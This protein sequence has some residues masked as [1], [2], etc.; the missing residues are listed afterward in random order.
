MNVKMYRCT[1]GMRK[2]VGRRRSVPDRTRFSIEELS[3]ESRKHVFRG[4]REALREPTVLPDGLTYR[5]HTDGGQ[6][7]LSVEVSFQGHIFVIYLF[8]HWKKGFF[9]EM[10]HKEIIYSIYIE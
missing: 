3:S 7:N 4:E 5:H 6:R 8:C 1:E 9:G 2:D 10:I